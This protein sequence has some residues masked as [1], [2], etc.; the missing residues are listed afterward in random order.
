MIL[1]VKW[2]DFTKMIGDL[3]VAANTLCE[4]EKTITTEAEFNDIKERIAEWNSK[5][6][7]LL[8]TSFDSPN[9]EF[10]QAFKQV[11]SP[12]YNL[13]QRQPSISERTQQLFSDL[14]EK[15]N[16]LNY[17]K[18][19]L[20]ISDAIIKPE[21]VKLADRTSFTTEETLDLILQKLFALYDNSY[22]SIQAILEGNGIPIKR[23][24]EE[25]EFA[26]MLET[27]GY[28]TLYHSRNTSAQLT[29]SGRMYVEEKLK[30]YKENYND[31]NK[32]PEEINSKIDEI[33]EKLRK[34]GYGQEIIFDE[35][36]EL[37]DLYVHLNKKNWGQVVKGK[38]VDL[39]LAK[40]I[41]KDTL[42]YIYI[43]L[44]NHPMRLP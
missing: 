10:A 38:L 30:T 23:Y 20:S 40:L 18:K 39:V 2:E 24:G 35:I 32:S 42:D 11:T 34:L 29:M 12:K 16:S 8:E 14:K 6:K 37:K 36:E 27:Y 7:N 25:R 21:I 26:K 28:V 3:I 44:T 5:A 15:A 1:T 4:S 22:H 9:N 31:I 17:Y 41:E 33:L 43:G 19:L 13:Q